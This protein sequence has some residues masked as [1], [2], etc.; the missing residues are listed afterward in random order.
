MTTTSHNLG[1]AA[2]G[3]RLVARLRASWADWRLYNRTLRELEGLSDRDL[4]D[5]GFFRHDIPRIARETVYGA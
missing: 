3:E 1:Y 2:A 4:D 5:L